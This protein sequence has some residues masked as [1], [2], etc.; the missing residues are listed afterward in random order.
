MSFYFSVGWEEVTAIRHEL[1]DR[2]IPYEI[3][4]SVT[5]EIVFLFPD[6]P[7]RVYARVRQI[8]GSNGIPLDK[9]K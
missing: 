2:Y 6:L 1:D 7:P 9:F 5:G 4:T 3:R 8:F